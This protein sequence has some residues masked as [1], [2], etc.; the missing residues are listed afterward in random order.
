MTRIGRGTSAFAVIWRCREI[1][2]SSPRPAS[3]LPSLAMPDGPINSD[4]LAI[5][6]PNVSYAAIQAAL[7]GWEEWDMV[8][9]AGT[10]CWISLVEIQRRV[11]QAGLGRNA[12]E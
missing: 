3:S 1:L 2:V 11:N 10:Y 6:G 8:L 5:S 12:P 9:D 4:E 7:E